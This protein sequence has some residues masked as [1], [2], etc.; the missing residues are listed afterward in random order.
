MLKPAT[1][2]ER[3]ILMVAAALLLYTGPLQDAIGT[4][5]LI[6]GVTIHVLRTRGPDESEAGVTPV[7]ADRRA[8]LGGL[9]AKVPKVTRFWMGVAQSL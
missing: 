8:S 7:P 6:V 3:G 4:G 1:W 9:R 2:L 5:L